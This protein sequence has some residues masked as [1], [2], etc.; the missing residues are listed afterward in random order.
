MAFL[1][2]RIRAEDSYTWRR[3]GLCKFLAM[4]GRQEEAGALLAFWLVV[5]LLLF[6]WFDLISMRACGWFYWEVGR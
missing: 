6:I 4:E 5:F 1:M 3:G 2:E